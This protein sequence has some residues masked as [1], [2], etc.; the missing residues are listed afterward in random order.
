MRPTA[1]VNK[2]GLER[3]H[4]VVSDAI[5][6]IF[7]LKDDPRYSGDIPFFVDVLMNVLDKKPLTQSLEDTRH[8]QQG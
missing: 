5:A 2:D 3:I 4:G 8:D 1:S 7:A 6:K